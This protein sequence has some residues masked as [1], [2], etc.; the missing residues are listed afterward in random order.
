MDETSTE[1]IIGIHAGR[2]VEAEEFVVAKVDICLL[3]DGT[4]PLAARQ[5]EKLNL[6]KAAK[7]EKTVLFI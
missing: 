4:A 3:H 7:P 6:V 5:L 1:R 2:E